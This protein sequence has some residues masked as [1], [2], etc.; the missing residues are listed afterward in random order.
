MFQLC[1][2]KDLQG[3]FAKCQSL[4]YKTSFYNLQ[5]ASLISSPPLASC[6]LP[7]LFKFSLPTHTKYTKASGLNN[8]LLA[9]YHLCATFSLIIDVT[10]DIVTFYISVRSCP[11]TS[12]ASRI[13]QQ[14]FPFCLEEVSDNVLDFEN[15]QA[16]TSATY[17]PDTTKLSPSFFSTFLDLTK[18]QSFKIFLLATP[19]SSCEYHCDA[20]KIADL[21]TALT[22]L[23]NLERFH[24]H[25]HTNT[26]STT[27]TNNINQSKNTSCT[28]AQTA[29]SVTN[30]SNTCTQALS[31]NT[32]N[33]KLLGATQNNN[34]SFTN[35]LSETRT[36]NN[37]N[38]HSDQCNES[39]TI[40]KTATITCLDID[41]SRYQI[42]NRH[43]ISLLT[44]GLQVL[45]H[46]EETLKEP[47]YTFNTFFTSCDLSTTLIATSTFLNLVSI[48]PLYPSFVYSWSETYKCFDLLKEELLCLHLFE[49]TPCPKDN[50]PLLLG[51]PVPASTLSS[52]LN[53]FLEN[54]K[55]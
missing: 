20:D 21:C 54:K 17:I 49:F 3:L 34:G 30:A 22:P 19:L 4:F 10:P 39:D 53:M 27:S 16:I 25:H 45:A 5:E 36:D 32:T 8:I 48:T 24:H 41:S 42:E 9:L 50:I 28:N 38:T 6:S 14:L 1:D 26:S 35:S 2:E 7:S 52:F 11:N 47:I 37:S 43:A 31:L 23:K 13:L 40:T 29:T 51:L 55:S 46:Y 33:S 44:Q 18:G 12:H 15:I